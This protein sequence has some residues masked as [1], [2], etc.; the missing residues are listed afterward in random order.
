[1]P[2]STLYPQT[3]LPRYQSEAE[4]PEG[5]VKPNELP[6]ELRPCGEGEDPTKPFVDV[7]PARWSDRMK[8]EV[9]GRYDEGEFKFREDYR[10]LD[11][12][13]L[14]TWLTT[15]EMNRLVFNDVIQSEVG[16][17]FRLNPRY[18]IL[19]KIRHS[20]HSYGSTKDYNIFVRHY[21]AIRRFDFGPN[22][23]TRL[24]YCNWCSEKGH[25]LCTG[26]WMDSSFLFLISLEGEPVLKISFAT[27]DIGCV[28]AQIQL[29][30]KK[31]NRWLYKMKKPVVEYA[32]SRM[33]AAWDSQGLVVHMPTPEGAVKSIENSYLKADR[34]KFTDE[35]RAHVFKTYSAPFTSLV[36]GKPVERYGRDW[37]PVTRLST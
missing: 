29:V 24:D 27:T 22:F 11:P 36:R 7:S 21:N 3:I 31:G 9:N 10:Y 1:M 14:S 6:D 33:A 13:S 12:M 26:Q 34:Y 2:A 16:E 20:I 5:G 18:Y 15:D 8:W 17:Y 32:M 30:K 37:V 23:E 4:W 35:M 28:V 25:G 19:D